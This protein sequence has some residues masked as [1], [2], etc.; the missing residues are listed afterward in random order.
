MV[1]RF[2]RIRNRHSPNY[3]FTDNSR[4]GKRAYNPQSIE[5]SSESKIFKKIDFQIV[6]RFYGNDL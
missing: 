2:D 5:G 4:Y 6:K 1:S 3:R